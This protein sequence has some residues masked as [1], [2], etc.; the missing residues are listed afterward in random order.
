MVSLSNL[1]HLEDFLVWCA[2]EKLTLVRLIQTTFERIYEHLKYLLE[3]GVAPVF[4]FGGLEQ[5]MPPMMSPRLYEDF[6]VKY[7]SQLFDLV[8]RY[9]GYAQVHCHGRIRGVL[10]KL[11]TMRVDLLDPV[12]PPHL[13]QR[14]PSSGDISIGEAKRRINGK[15]TLVGNI[16]FSDLGLDHSYLG[17][18][19]TA[20]SALVL[21]DVW[22]WTPFVILLLSAGFATIPQ[23]LNEASKIDGASRWQNFVHISLPLLKPLIVI[24]LLLRMIEVIKV[25]PTI[26]IITEGG[27]GIHT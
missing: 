22:E 18:P 23:E 9:G 6:V 8:H 11:I 16:Q 21:V 14:Y 27:P 2:V 24:V 13:G 17:D 25:F 15:M 26:F 3:H 1:F 4:H 12:E 20:L 5:A 7:D 10:D 19:K